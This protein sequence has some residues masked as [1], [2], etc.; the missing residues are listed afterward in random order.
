[1]GGV[2]KA[3]GMGAET[4]SFVSEGIKTG[5]GVASGFMSTGATN[6]GSSAGATTSSSTTSSADVDSTETTMSKEDQQAK[7]A[8]LKQKRGWNK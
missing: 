1:M 7:L 3:I 6:G 2:Q 8:E 4:A 5:A